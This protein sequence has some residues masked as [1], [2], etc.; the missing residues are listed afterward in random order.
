[1]R[2]HRRRLRLPPSLRNTER[3]AIEMSGVWRIVTLVGMPALFLS[4]CLTLKQGKDYS[5][6]NLAPPTQ[7]RFVQDTAQA[8]SL[9]DLKWW[10]VFDDPALQELVLSLIHISEPTRLLSISYA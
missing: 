9:S 7:Y 2:R 8:A 4:G 10:E 1:M 5:R 6:P 3:R